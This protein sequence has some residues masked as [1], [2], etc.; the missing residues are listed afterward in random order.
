MEMLGMIIGLVVVIWFFGF[1]RSAR[2][3][4]DMANKEVSMLEIQQK[5]RHVTN[6]TN[7]KISPEDFQKAVANKAML[8]EFN[9]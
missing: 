7:I 2:A 6:M 5:I 1:H 8:D 9:L 4:A 3:L